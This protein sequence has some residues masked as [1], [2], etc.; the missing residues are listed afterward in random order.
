MISVL[1]YL[2]C[3]VVVCEIQERLKFVIKR[4]ISSVAVKSICSAY[5]QSTAIL[6]THTSDL[7]IGRQLSCLFW[8]IKSTPH[9][10]YFN[11]TLELAEDKKQ[12]RSIANYSQS[13]DQYVYRL[14]CQAIAYACGER[15]L[16]VIIDN[17]KITTFFFVVFW[18][19]LW[20]LNLKDFHVHVSLP[21]CV[22]FRILAQTV[23]LE[24]DG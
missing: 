12:H 7:K 5:T 15:L 16:S 3:V 23:N 22:K 10:Q 18:A 13:Y 6:S 2:F 4:I 17:K 20:I 19:V 14:L 24:R 8:D 21:K 9:L 1:W 11:C